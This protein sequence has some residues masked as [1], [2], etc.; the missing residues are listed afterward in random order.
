[1]KFT[2][3]FASIGSLLFKLVTKSYA[4]LYEVMYNNH[5]CTDRLT[6]KKLQLASG[7]IQN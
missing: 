1:M 6:K 7:T 5:L 3:I 2:Q 4:L